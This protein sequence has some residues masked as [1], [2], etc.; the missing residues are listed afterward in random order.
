M[1]LDEARMDSGLH[2]R[3]VSEFAVDKGDR[4]RHGGKTPH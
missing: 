3:A 2:K 4:V 1:S